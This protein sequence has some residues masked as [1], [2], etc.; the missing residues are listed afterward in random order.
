MS[1]SCMYSEK[2]PRNVDIINS[3]WVVDGAVFRNWI[4]AGTAI[5]DDKAYSPS[6]YLAPRFYAR[7]GDRVP[8]VLA[9]SLQSGF[10]PRQVKLVG[11]LLPWFDV[12]STKNID[13][14]DEMKAGASLKL[15]AT[16]PSARES[17]DEGRLKEYPVAALNLTRHQG[18][19]QFS[20]QKTI[21]LCR[22]FKGLAPFAAGAFVFPLFFLPIASW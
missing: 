6:S 21:F 10:D 20:P 1:S 14:L 11:R 5:Y 17:W 22:K 9:S 16:N 7:T 18:L 19:G 12:N 4:Y 8:L 3:T 13:L 15:V 2:T